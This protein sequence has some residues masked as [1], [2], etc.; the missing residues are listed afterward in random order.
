MRRVGTIK[1]KIEN[2]KNL[3]ERLVFKRLEN[4]LSQQQVAERVQFI[5]KKQQ[6]TGVIQ[7]STYSMY[8][9]GDTVPDLSK[10]E[11]LAKALGCRPAWLAFGEGSADVE[12]P[13]LEMDPQAHRWVSAG[14]LGVDQKWWQEVLADYRADE[15]VAVRGS[16]SPKTLK[17]GDV[18]YVDRGAVLTHEPQCAAF[19]R[20]GAIRIERL[21]LSGREQIIY[22]HGREG[23]VY[24]LP[25]DELHL[26]GGVVAKQGPH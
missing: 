6:S 20:N 2:P 10:I 17:S 26:L 1:N 23:G 8:E 7:R 24:E 5:N 9:N 14:S 11:E 16:S 22:L 21:S 15:I 19:V 3:H 4:H 13:V 12:I 25:A 18:F